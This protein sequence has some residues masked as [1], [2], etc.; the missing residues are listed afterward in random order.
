MRLA[1]FIGSYALYLTR[2]NDMIVMV[3]NVIDQLLSGH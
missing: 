2:R 1:G 3:Q